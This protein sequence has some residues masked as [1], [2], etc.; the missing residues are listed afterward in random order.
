MG[1]RGTQVFSR[2][3]NSSANRAFGSRGRSGECDRPR[4]PL[5]QDAR[6]EDSEVTAR[7]LESE[8]DIRYQTERG[9][10]ERD[11]AERHWDRFVVD[12][13]G[14]VVVVVEPDVEEELV[15]SREPALDGAGTG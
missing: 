7:L 8:G 15:P 11:P 1:R 6:E 3:R 2:H 9:M 12:A 13:V 5:H 14:R 4:N 10:E